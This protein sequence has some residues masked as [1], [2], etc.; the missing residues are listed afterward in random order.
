[1]EEGKEGLVK[2]VLIAKFKQ[3]LQ[4]HEIE[5]LIKGYANLVS[6]I[7][8]MKA[9]HW[10]TDVGVCNMDEGFTHIFESE[11][12]SSEGVAEYMAHPAHVEF[13]D[14]F[15][16]QLEKVVVIDYKPALVRL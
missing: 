10:G 14:L 11:F 12:E 1:M 5:E 16:P 7:P 8:P 2:H 3:G 13:A 9:F 4:S 6:L 15:L